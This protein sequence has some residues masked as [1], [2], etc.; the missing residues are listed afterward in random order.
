M[1]ELIDDH[2]GL[3][4]KAKLLKLLDSKSVKQVR[5]G[6]NPAAKVHGRVTSKALEQF[7][8]L[9]VRVIVWDSS[10][11]SSAL[12]FKSARLL[13]LGGCEPYKKVGH[14]MTTR[15][16]ENLVSAFNKLK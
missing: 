8:K 11:H 12:P 6:L 7:A 2:C 9:I 16:D 14:N 3:G 1:S 4:V 10:S 13:R 15:K 5:A